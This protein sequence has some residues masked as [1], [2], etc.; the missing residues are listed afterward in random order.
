[1]IEGEEEIGSKSLYHFCETHKE[2]LKADIILVSDTGMIAT[3]IP[4]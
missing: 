4:P 1:M 3:E 2:M